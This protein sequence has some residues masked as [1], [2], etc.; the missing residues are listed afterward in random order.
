MKSKSGFQDSRRGDAAGNLFC[1]NSQNITA[2]ATRLHPPDLIGKALD[3]IAVVHHRQHRAVKA[4]QGLL[5]LAAARDIQVVDG[6]IQ[7]QAVAAL[8]CQP[9][10]DQAGAL[11]VAQQVDRF[12]RLITGKQEFRQK[13]ARFGFVGEERRN[14]FQ[15]V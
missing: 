14:R 8:R 11:P 10:Q 15:G 13:G 3:E 2:Y 9:R 1:S 4:R 6:L 12:E 7:Q 5:K